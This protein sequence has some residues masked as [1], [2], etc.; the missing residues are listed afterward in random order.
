MPRAA[1]DPTELQLTWSSTM[2]RSVTWTG[3]VGGGAVGGRREDD[4]DEMEF[5]RQILASL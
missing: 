1:I 2:Y 3:M 4:G 5:S